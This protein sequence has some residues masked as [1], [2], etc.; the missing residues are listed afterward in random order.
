M[1]TNGGKQFVYSWQ[2]F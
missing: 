2:L 1:I